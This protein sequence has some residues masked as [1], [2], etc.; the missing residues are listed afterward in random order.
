MFP[1][2]KK[3]PRIETVL[4][5]SLSLPALNSIQPQ[6]R[7]QAN[8]FLLPGFGSAARKGRVSL[9]EKKKGKII[10]LGNMT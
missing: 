4:S 5:L 9:R 2:L 10:F 6:Q 3:L 8:R 7:N 1:D